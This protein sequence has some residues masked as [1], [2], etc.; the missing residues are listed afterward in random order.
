M[1][2]GSFISEEWYG[3]VMVSDRVISESGRRVY[4]SVLAFSFL[5]GLGSGIATYLVICGRF[6]VSLLD[7]LWVPVL[8]ARWL[9]LFCMPFLVTAI[10]SS[11]SWPGAM[12]AICFLKAFLF[13][14]SGLAI[15]SALS[16]LGQLSL[17]LFCFADWLSLPLLYFLWQRSYFCG[18]KFSAISSAAFLS[19]V[20]LI[21]CVYIRYVYPVLIA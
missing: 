3:I 1:L 8:P 21:G 12:I 5:V 11:I 6:S 9:M 4:R 18:D 7:S 19:W 2:L 14:F 10:C 15:C 13:G 20:F 17:V 16:G